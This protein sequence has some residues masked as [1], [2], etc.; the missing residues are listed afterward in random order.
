V[1]SFWQVK[2]QDAEN[3]IDGQ[4]L[5]T[6]KPIRFAVTVDLKDQMHSDN[7]RHD[8][9]QCKL[10]VHRLAEKVREKDEH[11]GD[12]ERDLQTRSH[13]NP[14]AETHLV[15]P[16]PSLPPSGNSRALPLKHGM[17]FLSPDAHDSLRQS[18]AAIYQ[19]HGEA[20]SR[21]S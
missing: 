9:G 18:D 16:P 20:V 7:H 12:K 8:L 5:H 13:G 14:E 15:F 21:S 11:R 1:R 19:P 6:L 4:K 2:K 3:Q 10:Q 17:N